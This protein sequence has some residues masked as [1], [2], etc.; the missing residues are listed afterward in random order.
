M[1][2]SIRRIFR[3]ERN[4]DNESNACIKIFETSKGYYAIQIVGITD[5]DKTEG[6]V[7]DAEEVAAPEKIRETVSYYYLND[8]YNDYVTMLTKEAEYKLSDI[9]Y[10]RM[11]EIAEKCLNETDEE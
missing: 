2:Y 11:Y 4:L 5:F 10:D 7:A 8:L 3:N 6:V 1:C 9:N